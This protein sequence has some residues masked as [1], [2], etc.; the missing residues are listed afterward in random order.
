MYI[1][2]LTN[3]PNLYWNT[4]NLTKKLGEVRYRQGKILGQMSALGFNLKEETILQTLTLDVTKSSEIEGVYLDNEQVRSSIAKR[5]G[6]EIAGA[7]Q[8]ERHVDGVVEMMLD[9]IQ[10]YQQPLSAERLNNWHGSLF[11]SGRSGLYKIKVAGLRD[12]PMQVVSGAMGKEK[13]HFEA[14]SAEKLLIEMTRFTNWLNNEQNLD[15]VIKAALAHLWFVT[16]HPFDDGNGRMTRAITDMLLARADQTENRFYSMSAQIQKD[17][18]QY[19]EILEKTQKG[20][21]DVTA[22]LNW[23][24]DCLYRAMDSTDIIL[25]AIRTRALFWEVNRNTTF[26]IRQQEIL[27]LLLDG[28]F[29]NLTVSKWSKITKA[30]KDTALRDIQDLVKKNILVQQGAGRSTN[31]QLIN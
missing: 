10:Q 2:E 30:S 24:L 5:L 13:I 31:Y 21:L 16:I 27:D 3:W 12:G 22:W 19:Y 25:D 9:A 23:F 17:R 14:P 4:K 1:H 8:T 15:P 29:G 20:S 26:N 18:N 11:P 6:I 28:F 7:I